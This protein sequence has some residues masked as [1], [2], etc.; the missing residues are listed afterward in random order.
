[1]ITV[2]EPALWVLS[3][4]FKAVV[5]PLILIFTVAI[6]T[7]IFILLAI[8]RIVFQFSLRT[9]VMIG[10]AVVFIV[11]GIVSISNPAFIPVSFDSGGVTTGP[12]AVPFIMALGMGLS[13]SRGDKNADMDTFG[14]IGIASIGPIISVLLLGLIYT[15]P[16]APTMDL[17]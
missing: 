15:T 17:S 9:L 3:D 12:M 13:K 10:Y 6:G 2:A 4:Q 11:A 1:L 16:N 5:N 14:L 7:G 8:L